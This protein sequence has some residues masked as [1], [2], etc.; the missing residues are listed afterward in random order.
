MSMR[1]ACVSRL[2]WRVASLRLDL[3]LLGLR[4]ALRKYNPDQLRVPA[5]SSDG[6]RWTGGPT[7][8]AQTPRTTREPSYADVISICV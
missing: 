5:G 3:M 2:D 6:G 4:R 8:T 7:R 1:S